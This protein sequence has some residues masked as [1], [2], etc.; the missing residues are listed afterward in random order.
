MGSNR[1]R[2]FGEYRQC[3]ASRVEANSVVV[4]RRHR[5]T[6]AAGPAAPSSAVVVIPRASMSKTRHS[7]HCRDHAPISHPRRGGFGDARWHEGH[8]RLG[9]PPPTPRMQLDSWTPWRF[10]CFGGALPR[11][12]RLDGRLDDW[13]PAHLPVAHLLRQRDL[14]RVAHGRRKQSQGAAAL[15]LR[16]VGVHQRHTHWRP[17]AS[18]SRWRR[19]RCLPCVHCGEDRPARRC[20][21]VPR[22]ERDRWRHLPSPWARARLSCRIPAP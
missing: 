5:L 7:Q 9:G 18:R 17:S 15:P 20:H 19:S 10:A 14:A 11:R 2:G 12:P 4:R 22:R 21:R 1:Q 16:D 3:Q 13:T 8:S 6:L